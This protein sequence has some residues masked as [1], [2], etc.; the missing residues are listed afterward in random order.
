MLIKRTHKRLFYI[1]AGR[2]VIDTPFFFPAISSVKTN[3]SIEEYLSLI[4][5]IRYPG[6]LVSSYDIYH[7]EKSEEN[8]IVDTVSES[9]EGEF[10]TLLDSGHYEAFWYNDNTWS[11]KMLETVL[12]KI[13]VDFCFSYD[14]FWDE[15]KKEQEYLKE[16]ITSIAKTAGMQKSGTTIPLLHSIP[17]SFPNFVQKVVEGI[18]PEMIAVPEREL[19]S[20]IFERAT[21]V[22]KIRETL[23]DT[24]RQIPLHLLGTGNPI[25]ILIYSM[26]GANLYDGL[27][28][29]QTVVN[30]ETGHLFHFAQKDLIDCDCNACKIKDISYPMQTMVH[31]L[32]FYEKFIKA[33]RT[34]IQ[35]GKEDKI[36][37]KYLKPEISR[38]IMKIAGLK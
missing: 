34:S 15:K 31:N 33:I 5:K 4:R 14:I 24:N 20:G 18:N 9:T 2:K 21:T 35:D 19:G 13:A 1:E 3:F 7:S 17:E 29:C 38:K 10:I 16:T 11:F 27:E 25:S 30:P 22:K 36:L 26:C 28:W 32:L 8:K 37:D 23:D 6:F 12:N